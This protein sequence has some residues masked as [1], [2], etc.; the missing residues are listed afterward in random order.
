MTTI[1]APTPPKKIKP[2]STADQSSPTADEY[3]ENPPSPAAEESS[4][5]TDESQ[6]KQPSP[7]TYAGQS[8]SRRNKKT[9]T[10]EYISPMKK[11]QMDAMAN[12][13]K[14]IGFTVR[15]EKKDKDFCYKGEI[16]APREKSKRLANRTPLE[17]GMIDE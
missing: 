15:E 11:L 6:Q 1:C 5:S 16:P 7:A 9:K 4:P 10:V 14:R 13:P 2:S 17:E 8:S 12:L 3:P